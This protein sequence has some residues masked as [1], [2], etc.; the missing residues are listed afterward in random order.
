MLALSAIQDP[1]TRVLFVGNSFTFGHDVPAMVAE[2]GLTRDPPLRL[3]V[4]TVARDGRT[5]ED[6]WREGEVA[7]RLKAA[8]WDVL[9]LQEQSSRPLQEPERMETSVRR[10][11]E[12]A[13]FAG[14][15]VILFQT[16]ARVDRPETEGPRNAAYRRIAQSVG[17][18]V[19][20]VGA[21]W[22]R[23]LRERPGVPLHAGDGLHA[24]PDGAHLAAAVILD[25]IVR[26]PR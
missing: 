3:E 12:L 1:S 18:V 26:L 16:W 4:E 10:F 17:V 2:L 5:L 13:R 19:A 25:A 15:R 8:R 24:N 6:H 9:V 22:S 11:A 7:R 21:A 14:A 23:A 20:R